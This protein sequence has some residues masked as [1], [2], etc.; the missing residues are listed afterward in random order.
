MGRG[1]ARII[2]NP[3]VSAA[4]SSTSRRTPTLCDDLRPRPVPP[5]S[6]PAKGKRALRTSVLRWPRYENG[7]VCSLVNTLLPRIVAAN[8][9]L[10]ASIDCDVQAARPVLLTQTRQQ[11]AKAMT[12]NDEL[13]ET[14]LESWAGP[15]VANFA[16]QNRQDTRNENLT[17]SLI[18]Q[19]RLSRSL[20]GPS[21]RT[22]DP[23]FSR[24]MALPVGQVSRVFVWLLF[25]F[26]GGGGGTH[27]HKDRHCYGVQEVAQVQQRRTALP[28]TEIR[29]QV[30]H[31]I[32]MAFQVF[33]SSSAATAATQVQTLDDHTHPAMV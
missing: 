23:L 33:G 1:G 7:D 9:A 16:R 25:F 20:N 18:E 21:G 32:A 8:T 22:G 17:Q 27:T 3:S 5:N 15:H 14:E 11:T 4:A 13:I 12:T 30:D 6:R 28:V 26:G 31:Q 10:I 19:Q 2:P 29:K 24:T